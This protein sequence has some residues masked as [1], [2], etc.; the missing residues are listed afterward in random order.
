VGQQQSAPEETA[1]PANSTLSPGQVIA[2]RYRLE[3]P[4]P[5][6]PGSQ[7]WR[8]TDTLLDVQLDIRVLLTESSAAL[9]AGRRA[10]L[11]RDPRIPQLLAA[12][13]SDVMYMCLAPVD[14]PS[15]ADILAVGPIPAEQARA[16]VGE[17]AEALAAAARRGIHHLAL[18]P[19]AV[20]LGEKVTLTGLAVDAVLTGVDELDT[21]AAMRADTVSLVGLLYQILTGES[22]ATG[23]KL[24][25]GEDVPAD[26]VTLCEETFRSAEDGPFTPS[27]LVLALGDWDYDPSALT[28][29]SADSPTVE[30]SSPD[31]TTQTSGDAVSFWSR[32]RTRFESTK[33]TPEAVPARLTAVAAEVR[34]D[35]AVREDA[36][37]AAPDAAAVDDVAETSEDGAAGDDAA[38]AALGVA[39]VDEDEA[40]VADAS[41]ADASVADASVADAS[42]AETDGLAEDAPAREDAAPADE[43]EAVIAESVSETSAEDDAP[44]TDDFGPI[45]D[46]VSP[47]L[48]ETNLSVGIQVRPIGEPGLIDEITALDDNATFTYREAFEELVRDPKTALTVRRT[49]PTLWVIG[50][51]LL[52]LVFGLWQAG[53]HL[54][55]EF[56]PPVPV[57][58]EPTIAAP[59]EPEVVPTAEPEPEEPASSLVPTIL[60]GEALDPFHDNNEHPEAAAFAYDEN[61]ET[62]WYSRTYRDPTMGSKPGI[63]YAITLTQPTTVSFLT[64]H[65]PSTGGNLEIRLTDAANPTAGEVLAAGP[66]NQTTTYNFATPVE[67]NQLV[68]WITELP[69]SATGNRI[70]VIEITLG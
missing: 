37:D 7:T 12:G 49:D 48:A 20:H 68:I 47:E 41:V 64:I 66:L 25:F 15:L 3:E 40:V 67:T 35:R 9:N 58:P 24:T 10:G 22:A 53:N 39:A 16:I 33:T 38:D 54:F 62:F 27:E 5:P 57:D 19:H 29:I 59:S 2:G 55:A 31:Q 11:I 8:A 52:I 30:A 28:T 70:E 14:D 56:N 1:P 18:T 51:I 21:P 45:F 26:L 44:D 23:G 32:L 6:L 69:V 34:E 42:V 13:R 61:P 46:V 60:S 4:R 36:A 17:L 63:G 43:D 65:S 50:A